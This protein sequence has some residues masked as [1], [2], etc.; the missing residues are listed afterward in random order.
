MAKLRAG[1]LSNKRLKPLGYI[2]DFAT[3]RIKC[4]R[5]HFM[6]ENRTSGSTRG[7]GP[8]IATSPT[9]PPPASAQAGASPGP[10]SR[11]DAVGCSQRRRCATCCSTLRRRR[12]RKQT[13]QDDSGSARAVIL[14]PLSGR[15]TSAVCSSTYASELLRSFAPLR[16]TCLG[17]FRQPAKRSES[18]RRARRYV[19][20][21][22]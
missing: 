15:R 9:L 12:H 17:I 1:V 21:L 11:I 7:E 20:V 14:S 19:L 6:R 10:T 22:K 4:C 13:A 5:Q 2:L 8:P 16:M 18:N 3:F